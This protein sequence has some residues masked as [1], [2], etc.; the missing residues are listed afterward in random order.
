VAAEYGTLPP[1]MQEA[2]RAFFEINEGWLT[3]QIEQ[4][5]HAGRLSPRLS[6]RDAARML[7]GALEGEMLV[8]RAYG[9]P[10]RFETASRML[11]A[12]LSDGAA[13]AP[14]VRRARKPARH[15]PVRGRSARRRS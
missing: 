1:Q 12:Q 13:A 5:V 7:V 10:S 3:A 8:A 14:E 4:G 15:A 9:D 2:I 6:P 11:L